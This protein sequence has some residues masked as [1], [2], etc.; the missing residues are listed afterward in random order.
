MFN[1]TLIG[2]SI[3]L[4]GGEYHSSQPLIK[5]CQEFHLDAILSALELDGFQGGT[6]E[7]FV[8]MFS[9]N[10]PPGFLRRDLQKARNILY[11]LYDIAISSVIRYDLAPIYTYVMYSIIEDWLA[12]RKDSEMEKEMPDGLETYL[13]EIQAPEDLIDTIVCWF[14]DDWF[15]ADDFAESYNADYV[16]ANFAELIAEMY[17]DDEDGDEKLDWLDV[18]VDEFFDLLPNDLRTRCMEKHEKRL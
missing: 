3:E 16:S 17:L 14:T 11:D 1:S 9:S 15:C 10:F 8:E 5:A 7:N 13:E 2:I 6:D 18:K 4:N 12:L